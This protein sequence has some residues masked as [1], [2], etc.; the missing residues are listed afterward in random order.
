MS[1]RDRLAIKF[2]WFM[3]WVLAHPAPDRT[4]ESIEEMDRFLAKIDRL[5]RGEDEPNNG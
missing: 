2:H 1:R 5:K 3:D 4:Q